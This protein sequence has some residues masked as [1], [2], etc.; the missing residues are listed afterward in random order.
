MLYI[1]CSHKKKTGFLTKSITVIFVVICFAVYSKQDLQIDNWLLNLSETS[2]NSQ[3]NFIFK[4]IYI[5]GDIYVAGPV[6]AIALFWMI[7]R[8]YKQEAIGFAFATL[9]ILIL[10][11]RVLKPFFDRNRP[12]KP[13]LVDGLSR[14][15]FPSGHAA[16][17][18][19]LYFYLSFFY[20][21]RKVSAVKSLCICRS[22]YDSC[23]DRFC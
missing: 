4:I 23:R 20:N 8:N 14:H 19:V 5:S 22:N 16:G 17:N 1:F 15:S 12:P 13:R 18:L 11:D 9:G 3:I 7:W 10:I 2:A 6:V 21:C